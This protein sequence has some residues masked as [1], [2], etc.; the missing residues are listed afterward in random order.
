[1]AVTSAIYWEPSVQNFVSIPS[2]LTFL[3]QIVL[4]VTSVETQCVQE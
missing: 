3:L 1:L 4:G 2:Y